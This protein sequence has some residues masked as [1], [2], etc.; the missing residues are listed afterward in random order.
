ME[1][2]KRNTQ[3]LEVSSPDVNV[4]DTGT[5]LGRGAFAGR[6]FFPGD[7]VETAPVILLDLKAQPFP[8]AIRRLAYNWS[9]THVALALGFGSLYNHS[10]QPNLRFSR[11]L[12]K[13]TIIFSAT[14]DIE[15]GEQLT[16]SYDYTGSGENPRD[17][18][19]FEIHQVEQIKINS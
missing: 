1:T 2:N 16:I 19:W 3:I 14:R 4:A 7:I 5:V 10:D 17:K 12:I 13:Q 15:A 8:R 11:D 18:S 9:K 6:T